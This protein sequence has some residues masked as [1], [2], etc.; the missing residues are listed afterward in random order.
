MMVLEQHKN[1][2]K[3]PAKA[4]RRFK[5]RK[6]PVIFVV[7]ATIIGIAGTASISGMAY[8]AGAPK[9]AA[10]KAKSAPVA[11]VTTTTAQLQQIPDTLSLTGSISATDPLTIGSSSSG[12]VI[13]QV[14]AEEGDYVRKGQVLAT[15]DSSVLRAQL[16]ASEARLQG[17]KASLV[18]AT[19]PNRPEDIGSFQAAHKQA[20]ADVQNKRAMLDQAIASR[21][22]SRNT[23]LRY[24][25]L[26]KDG[27]VS[28]MEAQTKETEA[29]TANSTVKAAEENLSAAQFMA[30]QAANKL[31]MATQGGRTEDVVISQASANETAA[32]VQQM[33][34]Q[35][36]QTIVRAPDDGLITK[37]LAHIGDVNLG[38][39]ALFEMI[40][41]GDIELRA[42]VS[43]DD[44]SRLK[45]GQT[46]QITDGTR[47]ANGSVF[48]ISP[49]VDAT[50]RLGIVRISIPK[51]S[52][53][54]PGM[55]VTGKVE[56][57]SRN[58]LVVPNSA[59]LSEDDHYYVFIYK[60]GIALKRQVIVGARVKDAA[61]I[62][63]GVQVG[64]QIIGAGA[65]FL[66]DLD[67]V[68][69]GH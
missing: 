21:Q 38:G 51:T 54:K 1:D 35:I 61:E 65:G 41:R 40:R 11:T 46:A 44:I 8:M 15:L 6:A 3:S 57:G 29:I 5:L 27:A 10:A 28:Q 7:A 36:E 64:D 69:L 48:L 47:K 4:E 12:L 55:F 26:L 53:F 39:K 25:S 50:T 22:L 13:T 56:R 43:Q 59:V 33:R 32:S 49:T 16:A 14:N 60:D 20:L 23:A 31:A 62:H 24:S 42:Q 18:K 34:A 37:K 58:A 68:A 67:P 2:E 19:Q 66:N 63:E 45:V 9:V 52:D 30:Q 17:A